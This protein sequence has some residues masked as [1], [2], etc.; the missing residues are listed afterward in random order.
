MPDVAQLSIKV[1]SG[2]AKTAADD[3]NR[4]SESGER[5]E[6]STSKLAKQFVGF[7][8]GALTVAALA[9]EMADCAKQALDFEKAMANVSTLLKDTSSMPELTANVKELS[10]EFGA[11]PIDTAKA[12]YQIISAGATTAAEATDVLVASN[13]FAV[14][15]M[16]ST[17]SAADALTTVMNSY[18]G[19]VKTS[20]EA[21][22]AMFVAI[23]DGKT[24]AEE[25]AK[26][27]GHVAPAAA[28]MGVS[29]DELMASAAT[30]TKAGIDT[31]IAMT[32]LRSIL[33]SVAKPSADAQKL[34][35][36]LGIDYSVAGLKAKGFAG[37]LADMNAKTH[38]S[39]EQMAQLVGGVEALLPAM[40]L[41]GTGAKDFV[42]ILGD[43][44]NKSG[45]TQ[46]A[47][48]K[49]QN[50][51]QY[52]LQ[53][54]SSQ[55]ANFKIDLGES[56]M[57]AIDP[58]I[59]TLSANFG[60]LTH[61][62]GEAA[63]AAAL[64]GSMKLAQLIG[65]WI[66][67]QA[68]HVVALVAE[69]KATIDAALAAAGYEAAE[70]ESAAASIAAARALVA[71]RIAV[72]EEM[73]AVTL[74]T[75]VRGAEE[76][77]YI[78]ESLAASKAAAAQLGAAEA[79]TIAGTAT[80]AF[81]GILTMLGG[82]VGIAT[83]LIIAGVAAILHW[84]GAAKAAREETEKWAA[85]TATT[86][87]KEQAVLASIKD[88]ALRM[89]GAF[90]P[91]S[92]EQIA[93]N[94]AQ[95]QGFVAQLR[96]LDPALAT[97]LQGLTSADDVRNKVLADEQSR[98]TALVDKAKEVQTAI[99]TVPTAQRRVG[100]GGDTMTVSVAAPR[101]AEELQALNQELTKI[102]TAIKDTQ[103]A[104][105][106]LGVTS[107]G[108]GG[109]VKSLAELMG[110]ASAAVGGVGKNEQKAAE[111]LEK[112]RSTLVDYQGD[113]KLSWE[114]TEKMTEAY[115]RLDP[116]QQK[117][118][119]GL[120]HEIQLLKD[121]APVKDDTLRHQEEFIEEW[122]HLSEAV[123]ESANGGLSQ[124]TP[125]ALKFQ[126]R[127][128]QMADL[129]KELDIT[130]QL[131]DRMSE[132]SE[133]YRKHQISSAA[134]FS[135]LIAYLD[136]TSLAFDLIHKAGSTVANDLANGFVNM[137]MGVKGAFSSMVQ[138]ILADLARL[139]AQR[140][141]EQLLTLGIN[142]LAG[143]YAPTPGTAGGAPVGTGGITYA[144][145]SSGAGQP[146]VAAPITVSLNVSTS[147]KTDQNAT[148]DDA[149]Q[150]AKGLR[151]AVNKHLQDEMRPG[152]SLYN[153]NR[154]R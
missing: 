94:Q 106:S 148:R 17:F 132:V 135:E 47:L 84:A 89:N 46:T 1:D 124:F 133:L 34:A 8:A 12:L 139:A 71:K 57:Q 91:Q 45:E 44:K 111:Y 118:A 67:K 101:S 151:A 60:T 127:Q 138:S 51:T 87:Q 20:T 73:E 35:K 122:K 141:F 81:N 86:V 83:G 131:N 112:L 39:I 30:L 128:K 54:L 79:A 7:A 154:G 9:R 24:T 80:E 150:F 152:G 28:Q 137:A 82:P 115:K 36:Q 108:T 114:E 107:D 4:L 72:L 41:T 120:L 125:D 146:T 96:A 93:Q 105:S 11:S 117:V 19:Q 25:L 59:R 23:R 70:T 145:R 95:L 10:Q 3:L 140:A 48:E 78:A 75:S 129:Q 32:D 144:V 136:R 55:F 123:N 142:A 126:E 31:R 62:M 147:G 69:K 90:G 64:F 33:S 130:K 16:T 18:A 2:S 153:L 113:G 100:R 98:L 76:A 40:V 52:R 102:N 38:G 43:M 21:T 92:T 68:E 143:A 42:N 104:M 27:V 134:Y 29:F 65:S 13:K 53:Q 14:A 49:V 26:Y 74:S 88:L 66:A 15:G 61:A 149:N 121:L 97:G 110:E 103:D 109:Q 56:A 99:D 119:D 58:V 63:A 5:A 22:D 37:F 6:T 77:A 50:T 116:A 85:A